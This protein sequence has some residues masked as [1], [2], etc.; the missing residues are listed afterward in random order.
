MIFGVYVMVKSIHVSDE[1]WKQ[2]TILKAELK[3]RSFDEVISILLSTYRNTKISND[4]NIEIS[5]DKMIQSKTVDK[6]QTTLNHEANLMPT[7]VRELLSP[8]CN[9]ES[10]GNILDPVAILTLDG[11]PYKWLGKCSNCNEYYVCEFSN[12]NPEEVIEKWTKKYPNIEVKD[13][14]NFT[15]KVKV[16]K[17]LRGT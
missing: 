4:R 3:K 5:S 1:N 6:H 9:N 7:M 11:K 17:G 8:I 13:W 15:K 12:V 2:L 10:C 14:N 16:L